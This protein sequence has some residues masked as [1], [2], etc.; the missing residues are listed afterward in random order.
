MTVE[1]ELLVNV[2]VLSHNGRRYL[3]ACL[4]SVLD[5]DF[6]RDLYEVVLVDNGS[7][8]GSADYVEQHYPQVQVVRLDR[9]YGCAEGVN[10]ALPYV[11]SRYLGFLNQDCVVHRRWLSELL[12]ALKSDPQARL[13]HSN[14]IFPWWPEYVY[15]ERERLVDRAYVCDVTTFGIHDYRVV[16]VTINSQPIPTLGAHCGAA[17]IDLSVID[18]LGY[19]ADTDFFC[20]AED[21]DLA[22]RINA[23]GYKVLFV[24]KSVAYHAVDWRIKLN[25]RSLRK[26]LWS[27]RNTILAFYKLSYVLEFIVLLP[28]ILVGNL[29]KAR[30]HALSRRA[31]WGYVL[32][33]IPQTVLGLTAALMKFPAYRKKRHQMLSR[34]VTDRWWLL[35]QL[36]NRGW[37]PDPSVWILEPKP[38]TNTSPALKPVAGAGAFADRRRKSH[39]ST[40]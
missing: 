38:T 29:Q 2:I 28:L 27:T 13:A 11:Q 40:F 12:Q 22:L 20:Y 30:Q 14:T 35:R 34:R 4:R 32:A 3:D 26:A 33:S 9:N 1:R 36:L 25:W 15:Q 37:R 17:M 24:P 7:T 39:D 6:P 18:E 8:D 21:L 31:Q 19:L 23:L 10:R 16:P 5:Q